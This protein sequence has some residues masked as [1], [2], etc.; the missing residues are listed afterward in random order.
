M[1]GRWVAPGATAGPQD[2]VRFRERTRVP[3]RPL[4]GQR[5]APNF[6]RV[7]GWGVTALRLTLAALVLAACSSDDPEA[8]TT[9]RETT[10]STSTTAPERQAST[11]T[12]AFDPATVEGEVEAAY[13]RSWDVYADAVYDLVLD[14]DALA[15]VF[16]EDHLETKRTEIQRRIDNREAAL[17]RIEHDYSIDPVDEQ[18][19]LLVDEYTNHQVLIDPDTKEPIE[20]DPNEVVADVVTLKYIDGAW[21]VTLK[22]RLDP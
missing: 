18:T 5:G 8:S 2:L 16:A 21:R 11:T 14:E 1:R 20:K 7:T 9:T 6:S 13:L 10:T 4:H 12:T 22:E 3:T 19:A 15:E 17:V